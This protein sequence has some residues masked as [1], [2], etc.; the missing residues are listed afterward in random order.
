MEE[1]GR[2]LKKGEVVKVKHSILYPNLVSI[3]ENE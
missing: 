2:V 1:V 3:V